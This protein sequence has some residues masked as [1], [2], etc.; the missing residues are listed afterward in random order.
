MALLYH[1]EDSLT[2]IR[3]NILSK[4][5]S[6]FED[7]MLE[8]EAI[9]NRRIEADWYRGNAAEYG[10]D[11]RNTPFDTSLLTASQLEKVSAYKSL[12]LIYMYLMK[13]SSEEDGFERQSKLF[14]KLYDKEMLEVLN[15]GLD[16]D[17]DDDDTVEGGEKLQ[18]RIRRLKRC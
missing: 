16:Y 11:F 12:Q 14:E 13:D 17:W 9:V 4:G 18:P 15:V 7:Q 1:D 5:V 2:K 3:P 10:V 8:A 6:D